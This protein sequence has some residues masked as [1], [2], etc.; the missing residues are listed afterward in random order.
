MPL[1][2]DDVVTGLYLVLSY[3]MEPGTFHWMLC[4]TDTTSEETYLFHATQ[5]PGWMY[6]Y[7]L[8]DMVMSNTSV[9]AVKISNYHDQV[10]LNTL[11]STLPMTTPI[12]EGNVEFTCRIWVRAAIRLLNNRGIIRCTDIDGLQNEGIML[13]T[14]HADNVGSG[15]VGGVYSSSFSV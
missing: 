11:L 13:A 1:N 12:E 7:R 10:H 4:S 8:W 2:A 5:R 6:E 14:R 3:R 15:L 9:I